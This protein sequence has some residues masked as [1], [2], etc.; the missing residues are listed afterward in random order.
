MTALG[1]EG[2]FIVVLNEFESLGTP[3]IIITNYAG[4]SIFFGYATTWSLAN[5]VVLKRARCCVHYSV[6]TKGEIGLAAKGPQVG[7]LITDCVQEMEV[8]GPLIRVMR[9][10]PEATEQWEK[11]FW[12]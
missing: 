5:G 2:V 9:C 3:I 10:T 7:A 1:M 4:Y 11:G 12:K 8:S 6:E